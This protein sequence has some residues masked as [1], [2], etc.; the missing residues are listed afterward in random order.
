MVKP[1]LPR[2]GAVCGVL[3]PSWGG[4]AAFPKVF[5]AGLKVL[6]DRFGFRIREFATTRK[7]AGWLDAHPR[8][9][10]DDFN[11]AFADPEVELIVS[12]IG[13]SDAVRIL[14][15]LDLDLIRRYPKPVLGYSDATAY[16]TWLNLNG[17]VTYY[18][19]AVMSG[20]AQ[21]EAFSAAVDWHAGLFAG[22]TPPLEP[23]PAWTQGY[24]DW[25]GS[26]DQVLPPEAN[27]GFSWV[28]G[29]TATRGRLWGGCFEVLEM[30]KGT[31]Y[32]PAEEFWDGRVL[33][34]ET[35]EE[36]PLPRQVMYWLRNYGAMGVFGRLSALWV[37][38]PK[39]YTTE[40]AAEL[41]RVVK[42]VVAQEWG[43]ESLPIVM[44]LDFGHTDPRWALPLGVEVLTDPVG[45]RLAFLEPLFSV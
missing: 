44:D 16:L 19:N 14:P 8:D 5:D 12:S 33:F 23:F 40:E 30:L 22:R 25:A 39:D 11:A 6:T 21:I 45:Q 2:A 17:V 31:R 35:S 7:D 13:G 43:A 27:P 4:P 38:R 29:T 32:W 34:L 42:G 9:R 36:K 41:R 20:F 37:G 1:R 18:A 24:R 26:A 3:S 10:A 28:Q 15:F